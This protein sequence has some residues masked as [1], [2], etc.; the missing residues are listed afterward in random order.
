MYPTSV[1]GILGRRWKVK[2]FWIA[3]KQAFTQFNLCFQE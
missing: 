3:Y 1:F 2:S